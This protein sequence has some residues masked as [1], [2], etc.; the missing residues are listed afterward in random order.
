M[1]QNAAIYATELAALR[2]KEAKLAEKMKATEVSYPPHSPPTARVLIR[3]ALTAREDNLVNHEPGRLD[4][5]ESESKLGPGL[6]RG[7]EAFDDRG[8][9][10]VGEE[11]SRG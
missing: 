5:N 10:P 9:G 3:P 8:D 11:P 1:C 6:R 4:G 2:R 7:G